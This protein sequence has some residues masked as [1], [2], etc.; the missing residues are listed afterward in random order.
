MI[1]EGDVRVWGKR[2]FIAVKLAGYQ[3]IDGA[4]IPFSISAAVYAHI[5]NALPEIYPEGVI[6]LSRF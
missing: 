6:F 5:E 3:E 4:N 1:G 2:P